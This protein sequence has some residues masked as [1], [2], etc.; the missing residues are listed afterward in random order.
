M[1]SP[2][3]AEDHG[4]FRAKRIGVFGGSFDP[5]HSGHIH[6]ATLAMEAADLDEIR[7]L[8]CHIS[9]HKT[10]RPPSSGDA[11]AKWLELALAG[12]PWAKIDRTE[13]DTD[14]PS[15]SYNTLETLVAKQPGNDWFWI[16]GGDQWSA[17]HSW[18]HPEILS[19]LATFIV[20]ARNGADIVPRDGYRLIV[21]PGEHPASS[22]EIR[23]ALAAGE[24]EIPFLH[25]GISG[26]K[27]EKDTPFSGKENGVE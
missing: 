14:G 12:I 13:L 8:P 25:Q 10:D 16:M 6:L 3:H 19:R 18:K 15:F 22:T 9:P 17:L 26:I 7:F 4:H 2:C 11:R 1:D 24:M 20:L 21:V 23:R 27:G 5:V